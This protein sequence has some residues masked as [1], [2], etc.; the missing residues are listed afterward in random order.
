MESSFVAVM[1]QPLHGVAAYCGRQVALVVFQGVVDVF[2]IVLCNVLTHAHIVLGARH[3][4]YIFH[5]TDA[6]LVVAVGVGERVAAFGDGLHLVE[7]RVGDLLGGQGE[8]ALGSLGTFHGMGPCRLPLGCGKTGV[9]EHGL[10]VGLLRGHA[11]QRVV[12]DLAVRVAKVDVGQA[13]HF[14]VVEGL[15]QVAEVVLPAG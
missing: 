13:V 12:D 15:L 3:V 10:P 8:H 2:P 14:V 7:A 4:T 9:G 11:A 5:H 1:P 6:L